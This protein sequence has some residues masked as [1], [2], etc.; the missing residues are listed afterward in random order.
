MLL[1]KKMDDIGMRYIITDMSLV[2][3]PYNLFDVIHNDTDKYIYI[4][5]PNNEVGR[6]SVTLNVQLKNGIVH[7]LQ[8]SPTMQESHTQISTLPYYNS[9]RMVELPPHSSL[10]IPIS[11]DNRIWENMPKLA[12]AEEYLV[13]AE[14]RSGWVTFN[15]KY[16]KTSPEVIVSPWQKLLFRKM[17]IASVETE[18]L[19]IESMKSE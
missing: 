14:Y 19:I 12:D 2:G 6:F 15:G 7:Q 5:E 13:Q 8:R 4:I 9:P 10:A 1:E 16:S 17:R 18:Q 11:L 3:C